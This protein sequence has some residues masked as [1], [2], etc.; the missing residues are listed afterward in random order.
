M[1]VFTR[2]LRFFLVVECVRQLFL[3]DHNGYNRKE[4]GNAVRIEA[5][6]DLLSILS[7]ERTS[8]SPSLPSLQRMCFEARSPLYICR[9]VCRLQ[10]LS[11]LH[12]SSVV[13][14]VRSFLCQC[15]S[16]R[17]CDVGNRQFQRCNST[18]HGHSNLDVDVRIHDSL[19]IFHFLHDGAFHLCVHSL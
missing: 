16:S 14:L 2:V 6:L 5:R 19:R 3:S 4:S 8:K 17:I 11:L 13:P 7:T 12:V 1:V 9:K 18:H 15:F 10:E